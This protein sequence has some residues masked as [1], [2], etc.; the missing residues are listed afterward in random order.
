M[1]VTWKPVLGLLLGIPLACCAGCGMSSHCPGP[2]D[3]EVVFVELPAPPPPVLVV[4]EQTYDYEAPPPVHTRPAPIVRPHYAVKTT[5]STPIRPTR[6]QSN[7]Q[8]F[9]DQSHRPSRRVR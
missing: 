4:Y 3:Y 2:Y 6:P 7:E 9:K 8:R 1:R 5:R